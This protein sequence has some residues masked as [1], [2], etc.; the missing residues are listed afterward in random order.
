MAICTQCNNSIPD[1]TGLCRRC[2]TAVH[3]VNHPMATQS[4]RTSGKAIISLI[5]GIIITACV[6]ATTGI[7]SI[8]HHAASR[9][10]IRKSKGR[11]T[12]GGLAIAGAVIIVIVILLI[13]IPYS[14]E[15]QRRSKI[16]AHMG[17]LRSIATALAAYK[18][19]HNSYPSQ[20]TPMLTTPIAFLYSIPADSFGKTADS[21]TPINYCPLKTK[22][23]PSEFVLW[24]VGPDC[25]SQ[26]SESEIKKAAFDKMELTRYIKLQLYD[27]SNGIVSSGDIIMTD[28]SSPWQQ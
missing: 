3:S 22:D 25:I 18:V 13:A 9:G 17:D 4:T 7:P 8:I 14:L 6:R 15:R 12:G 28:S 2:G 1:G 21:S 23:N 27:P 26:L 10:R 16:F 24:G 11:L 20:L 5:I 19:E